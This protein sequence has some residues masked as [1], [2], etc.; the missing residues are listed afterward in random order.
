MARLDWLSREL[1]AKRTGGALIV[2][3]FSNHQLTLKDILDYGNNQYSEAYDAG[4]R[5]GLADY[6]EMEQHHGRSGK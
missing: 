3:R 6:H 1:L 5:D 2:R 4:Y